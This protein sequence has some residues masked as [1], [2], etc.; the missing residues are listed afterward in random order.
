MKQFTFMEKTSLSTLKNHNI[1]TYIDFAE[2]CLKLHGTN[3]P[4]FYFERLNYGN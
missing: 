3:P 4:N 1:E 2:F